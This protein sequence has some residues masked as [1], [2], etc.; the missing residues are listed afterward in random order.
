MVATI[1]V[2]L[3]PPRLSCKVNHSMA[4]HYYMTVDVVACLEEPRQCGVS[5]GNVGGLTLLPCRL[6]GG[7]GREE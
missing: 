1:T 6:K 5:V 7:G 2:L 4:H 3:L